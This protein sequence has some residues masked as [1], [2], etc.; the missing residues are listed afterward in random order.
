MG[1]QKRETKMQQR[2]DK[3]GRGDKKRRGRNIK[4]ERR[5]ADGDRRQT[6]GVQKGLHEYNIHYNV[7]NLLSCNIVST[8]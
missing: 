8:S 6:E 4:K 5:Q 1:R 2:A 3:R 7:H